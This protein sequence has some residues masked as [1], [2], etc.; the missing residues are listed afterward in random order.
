MLKTK[1]LVLFSGGLDSML[2]AKLL[3]EQGIEV[4]GVCFQSIFFTCDKVRKP[5]KYVNIKLKV[6]DISKELLEIV[7]NPSSGY[8]KHLNPCID[9]HAL[10]VRKAGEYLNKDIAGTTGSLV[11]NAPQDDRYHF[12]ATGEVLGQRPF[13]QNK[14][15]LEKMEKLTG[16]EILRP[17]SA[18]LL[19]ETEIEKKGLVSRRR[20]L[21]IHGRSR[22]QQMELVK[23]YNLKDYFTPAG[24]CLLTDPGFSQRLGKMLDY[25]PKCNTKDVELLKYGRIFWLKV[26]TQ[27]GADININ[28]YD[29]VLVI[30]GRHKEDNEHLEKLAQKNDVILELKEIMGPTTIIKTKNKKQKIKDNEILEEAEIPKKLK[31]SEL[32]LGQEKS[33]KEIIHIAAI[34]TGWYA[35]KARGRKVKFILR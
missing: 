10:M 18:K 2:A 24:G 28:N 25:W 12:I 16:I 14:Q 29:R 23:K 35:T 9:C 4:A 5:A 3:Q 27:I 1:A 34:L 8:G 19:P 26:K 21:D 15:A 33:S 7:K 13:S 17:L 11:A 22:E 31:M 20:L 6:V 30:V 32:K